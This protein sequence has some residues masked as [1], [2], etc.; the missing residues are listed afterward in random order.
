MEN[1]TQAI[2]ALEAAIKNAQDA[3]HKGNEQP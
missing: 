3:K 2:A 1:T